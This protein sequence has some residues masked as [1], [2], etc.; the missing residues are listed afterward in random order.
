MF[1]LISVTALVVAMAAPGLRAQSA[2]PRHAAKAP[3]IPIALRQVGE[4]HE[5]RRRVGTPEEKPRLRLYGV[6]ADRQRVLP[7][8]RIGLTVDPAPDDLI[9]GFTKLKIS[10]RAKLSILIGAAAAAATTIG[11]FSLLPQS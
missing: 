11:I 8:S 3:A 7:Y 6:E 9:G 1:K 10:R 2:S 4:I 5:V